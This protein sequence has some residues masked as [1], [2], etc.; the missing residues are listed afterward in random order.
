[1]SKLPFKDLRLQVLY[2]I[3]KSVTSQ[4]LNIP[5]LKYQRRISNMLPIVLTAST[6][7]GFF[8]KR[9]RKIF[10]NKTIW[11]QIL[12]GVHKGF[13]LDILFLTNNN[14]CWKLCSLNLIR[15]NKCIKS[16]SG[17]PAGLILQVCY[18]YFQYW[19]FFFHI[20]VPTQEEKCPVWAQVEN[21]CT[22][23]CN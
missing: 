4:F 11:V 23:D 12:E 8:Q 9:Q 14:P 20:P 17:W 16:T 19:N 7:L 21:K 6:I 1:M 13:G 2:N 22:R 5:K 3:F 10:L 15:M 18:R